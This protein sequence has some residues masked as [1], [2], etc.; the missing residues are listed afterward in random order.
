VPDPT[1]VGEGFAAALIVVGGYCLARLVAV[2]PLDRQ[3]H[4]DVNVG[5]VLMA[6]AMTGMLVPGWRTLPDGVWGAVFLAVGLWFLGR[7]AWIVTRHGIARLSGPDG[8]HAR[9]YAVHAVMAFSMVYMDAVART[10][11]GGS[12]G[13]MAMGPR[14]GVPSLTLLFMVV[15]LASAAW[16]LNGI[17][18]FA[19]GPRV[20]GAGAMAGTSGL[21]VGERA[22]VGAGAPSGPGTPEERPWLAPRLEVGCHIAMCLAMAYML[23]LVV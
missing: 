22:S 7:V 14:V 8:L 11:P 15:L 13:G 18:A 20:V 19:A 9:H 4:V 21:A 6:V 16:Q 3:T 2:V 17:Q 12:G 10:V 5:H 23:V 1:W